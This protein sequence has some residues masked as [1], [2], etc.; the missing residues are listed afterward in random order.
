[1]EQVFSDVWGPTP[2]S[3]GNHAYY[4]SFIDDYSKLTWIY[5]LKK[6]SKFYQ[7]FLNFQQLVEQ[8]FGRKIITMQTDWAGEY[9]KLHGLFQKIG[10]THHV[11]CPHA[12]LQSGSAE[13]KHHHIVE[14]GLALL[15][16]P[17]MP[18]KFWDEAFL[19]ATFLINLLPSKF[20][21]FDIPTERLLGTTPN[22]DALRIFGCACWPNLHPYN[23][24]KLAFWYS[25][26]HKG[27][28]CCI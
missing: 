6:C 22:Y 18:L 9:E 26:H 13:C 7:V 2:V 3:F 4:V 24:R 20:I 11:S 14:V 19:T 25:P 15:A 23:K 28:K 8:K 10:I 21:D 5:L 12:H 17:S 1:L 16:H 27:V